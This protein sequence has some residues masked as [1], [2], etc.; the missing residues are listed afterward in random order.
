MK[1][2]VFACAALIFL[3]S[4]C[5]D[6]GFSIRYGAKTEPVLPPQ[7][8]E[9]KGAPVAPPKEA[10]KQTE[11]SPVT[12]EPE[13]TPNV[14]EAIEISDE[15]L[16]EGGASLI[17]DL[18]VTQ[19]ISAGG[20]ADNSLAAFGH[21][22]S[23]N[24]ERYR[25]FIEAYPDMALTKALALV[26]VNADYGYYKNIT[27][28]ADPAEL[29]VFCNKNF[30]LPADYIP[31]GL[32]NIAGYSI[33]LTDTAATAF[34]DMAAAVKAELGL[35]LIAISAYRSFDY[36]KALFARYAKADGEGVA[37]TYS[38]RAGHSEHQTGLTVDLLHM[39]PSTGSLRRENFQ[40]TEQYAW[41]LEHAHEYGFILRYPENDVSVTGY[42][43]EPWH[44]RYI[45]VEDA[46]RMHEAEITTFEEYTG[47]FYRGTTPVTEA[48]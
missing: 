5:S 8:Q 43:F 25:A 14:D 35:K 19:G 29:L 48:G 6:I 28:I 32:R 15:S 46:T 10:V 3:L 44:W 23:K 27:Q 9:I 22:I 39:W 4:S 20:E 12:R 16:G 47:T 21:Y 11:P 40:N 1:R 13:E 26:N 31:E 41:M 18:S 2:I 38:A 37:E 34:E 45:G 33:M 42:L 36:Q 30:Q 24:E 7:S 17:P